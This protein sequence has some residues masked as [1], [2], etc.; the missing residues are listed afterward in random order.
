MKEKFVSKPTYVDKVNIQTA[1]NLNDAQCG[2]ES[3][4]I[5]A[6]DKMQAIIDDGN[7]R[8]LRAR[9][10]L[11]ARLL[12]ANVKIAETQSFYTKAIVWATWIIAFATIINLIVAIF[13]K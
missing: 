4:P 1:K 13:R 7:E 6:R 9:Q 5:I 8:G 3:D 2:N 10:D 11:E 12:E